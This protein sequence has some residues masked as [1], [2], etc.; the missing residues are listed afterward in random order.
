[1]YQNSTSCRFLKVNRNVESK[2]IL[3]RFFS[4]YIKVTYAFVIFFGHLVNIGSLNYA[5]LPNGDIFHCAIFLK[6]RC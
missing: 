6:L 3:M 5:G 1:M 2:T 4:S